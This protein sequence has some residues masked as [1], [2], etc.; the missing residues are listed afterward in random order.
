MVG[1]D[2]DTGAG[3]STVAL[4]LAAAVTTAGEWA[5]AVDLDASLG[6]RASAEAGV[7]LDRFAVVRP[8][9]GE[10]FPPDQWATA[11]AALLDGMSL[12][13][14]EVPRSI[15]ATD[16]RRLEARARE[17]E[18]ILVPLGAAA[19]WPAEVS[20]RVRALGGSWP[21]LGTGSGLLGERTV[22]VQVDGRGAAARGRAA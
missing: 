18:V 11:V 8:P 19:R 21:G 16:A 13:L 9:S 10:R 20:L 4:T 12:V 3:V 17:R 6:G 1:V 14:A 7:A 22:R 15:R 2:G 5:A